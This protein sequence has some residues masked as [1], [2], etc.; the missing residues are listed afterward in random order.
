MKVRQAS[1]L[2]ALALAVAGGA[3]LTGGADAQAPAAQAV[4]DFVLPDQHYLA[5]QLYRMSDAKAVVL[6][7]YAAGDATVKRDAPALMA[8]KAAYAKQGVEFMA[9]ASRLGDTR[10]KVA[11]DARAAGLD[12]PILFDYDQ[13]IGEGLGVTRAAEVFVIDP[14]TWTV[15]YRGPVDGAKAAVAGLVAGEK[16]AAV[17]RAATGGV[18]AFPER[19][20]AHASISYAKTI[21]PIIEKKCATCHQPGGIGPMA[22]NSYEQVKG[23]SPMIRE[24]I[25]THRMPPYL[26]DPT[27]GA[28]QDDDRLSGDQMKTLVHWVEAGA[29]RGKGEDPLAKVK[30]QAPD[31]PLGKPDVIVEIPEARIPASGVMDYQRP[32]VPSVLTEG[33]WMKATTFRVTDRQVVHHILTGVVEGEQKAGGTASES[34][35]GASL[36]GYGPGRGSNIA[37][38]G[39]GTWV[40]PSGGIAF[41]NHYTPYGKETVEKTQM[42]LYFFPKGQEPKYVLRT[43]GIFDFS[44]VIPPGEEWHQES[45]YIAVPKEMVLYGLTPHAHH[46]GGSVQVAVI[47]PNGREQKLLSLPR[48]EF[49]WQY[50][51]FLKD[52]LKIPAGSKVV[53]RWTFDNSRRNPSNPDYKTEVRWGEQSSEEML[54]LYLHYRWTDETVAV[55]KPGND[56][57]MQGG[58]MMG[59][60]DD[61]MDGK[62][63]K[64]E[65]KGNLG[66]NLAKYFAM[67]DTDK[68]GGVDQKELDAAMKLMPRRR[69]AATA[70]GAPPT[71]AGGAPG[72]R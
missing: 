50:E 27:V 23:F 60:M 70:Q 68:D 61:N 14:K 72:G 38:R 17:T 53:T 19:G 33:R 22:L 7:S 37:P 65:L 6:M 20:K 39:T 34:Q 52:P 9:V 36:G 12:L 57:L 47:Y 69:P 3:M 4:D 24:V 35:W 5:R 41:Q 28:F 66:E 44:L 2:A 16:V 62:L 25:R 13:L 40:P 71:P 54:A 18:I 59:V 67:I 26:A 21:A 56:K 31:W 48:Y 15:A 10:E 55:Q 43:F 42:G 8:L 51:Y 30:F 1:M 64:A 45:A 46:R 58:M 49:E 63:T 32:V 29:P 11:P